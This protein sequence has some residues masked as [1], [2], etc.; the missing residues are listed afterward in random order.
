MG[1]FTIAI[2]RR[3]F[4]VE[5]KPIISTDCSNIYEYEVFA[6]DGDNIDITL[7]GDHIVESYI[8]NGTESTFTDTVSVSFNSSLIIKFAIR[9]SG[10]SGIFNSSQLTVE[11]TTTVDVPDIYNFN[12]TR[13]NDS[14]TCE[15]LA[16]DSYVDN[17]ELSGTDLIFTSIL[18]GFSGTISLS[19]LIIPEVNDLTNSVTWDDVPDVNITESS[20]IQHE[21]ALTITESQIS[22][23]S[24]F[25]PTNLLIDYGFT[26]NS[27]NWNSAF[28]WGDHSTEGYLTSLA[29][30]G[31]SDYPANAAGALTNDGTGVLTWEAAGG[32]PAGSDT[33][34]QFNNGGVFG[35]SSSLTWDDSSDILSI[36]ILNL[37][38]TSLQVGSNFI[39]FA[40]YSNRGRIDL[41][42]SN[43]AT[44]VQ[45]SLKSSSGNINLTKEGKIGFNTNSPN[46]D[47]DFDFNG[48]ILSESFNLSA[49][50][51]APASAV[52]TGILGQIRITSDYIYVCTATDTWVRTAIT[53]W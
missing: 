13:D 2:D 15:S 30:A 12:E 50:N 4:S 31:L 25:S 20:V 21:G 24:H 29:F 40:E 32:L 47:N 28:G 18:N 39:I 23:L 51:T 11:N 17:V 14:I 3:T 33:E 46:S 7:L 45:L 41:F 36:G 49:L 6:T 35:S 38:D 43:S 8:L 48:S 52:D 19:S 44:S 34:I 5:K 16:Q 22:D 37:K 42:S 10:Q 27:T 9:N 1:L 53:T 26:D